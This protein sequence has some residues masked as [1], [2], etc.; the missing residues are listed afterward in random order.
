MNAKHYYA[1][2]TNTIIFF[3]IKGAYGAN[4][5]TTTM[6]TTTTDVKIIE[7]E[8]ELFSSR[9][10]CESHFNCSTKVFT[11]DSY[12]C[13]SNGYCCNWFEFVSEFQ[14]NAKSQ[15]PLSY[16]APTLLTIIT[17]LIILICIL[18]ISYCFSIFFCYCFKCGLF[19]KPNLIVITEMSSSNQGSDSISA[20]LLSPKYTSGE[21]SSSSAS[22]V[23]SNESPYNSSHR[24]RS[25]KSKGKK[26]ARLN[27]S[28]PSNISTAYSHSRRRSPTARASSNGASSRL[29]A[30]PECYVDYD[31][32]SPFL[33]PN[34]TKSSKKTHGGYNRSTSYSHRRTTPSAPA[35]SNS[36]AHRPTTLVENDERSERM[37]SQERSSRSSSIDIGESLI[38]VIETV[39]TEN[40]VKPSAPYYLDEKPPSYD[41]IIGGRK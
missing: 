4:L 34:K 26:S 10:K 13:P 24:H 8:R 38:D 39:N 35:R 30:K 18:F 15:T 31:T 14:G 27:Q 9:F 6:T 16:K 29:Y 40:A 12:C 20:D 28:Y 17:L 23:S 21:S 2:L 5:P 1:I 11:L 7:T 22:V 3:I 37:Q 36:I 19:K 33:I 25:R 32:E 41:D